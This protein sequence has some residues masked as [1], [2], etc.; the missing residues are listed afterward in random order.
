MNTLDGIVVDGFYCYS[1]EIMLNV[2]LCRFNYLCA[3]C[4]VDDTD[5]S[6]F[7]SGFD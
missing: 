3:E 5:R 1:G 6:L 7:Y 2:I 4:F